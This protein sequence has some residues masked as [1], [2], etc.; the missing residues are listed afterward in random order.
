M[1]LVLGTPKFPSSFFP[2]SQFM[3][4]MKIGPWYL[5][6]SSL[7]CMYVVLFILTPPYLA[8]LS[9]IHDFNTVQNVLVLFCA[10]QTVLMPCCA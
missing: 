7:G 8:F 3:A 2:I 4:M 10:V 1:G 5:L 9:I 6:S